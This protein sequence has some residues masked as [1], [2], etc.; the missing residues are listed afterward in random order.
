MDGGQRDS[1]ETGRAA[2]AKKDGG[3]LRE[4]GERWE[5]WFGGTPFSCRWSPQQPVCLH[6]QPVLASAR[7]P[8]GSSLVLLTREV[9]KGLRGGPGLAQLSDLVSWSSPSVC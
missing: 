7:A 6:A 8:T 2:G 5:E 9:C 4:G 1:L 3:R